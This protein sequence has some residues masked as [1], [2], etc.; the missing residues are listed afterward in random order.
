METKFFD[1]CENYTVDIHHDILEGGGPHIVQ[2]VLRQL[3]LVEKLFTLKEFNR[4]LIKFY[5]GLD[6][7]G[8]PV[9]ID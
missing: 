2:C 9:P 6:A 3:I 4:R 7:G 8:K 1:P 5:Y